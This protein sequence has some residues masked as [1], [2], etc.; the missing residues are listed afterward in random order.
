MPSLL[1]LQRNFSAA[2]VGGQT[3][4]AGIEVYRGN[5]FGNCAQ[6]LAAA[7]PIVRK[8]VGE[9]FF[10]A[11]ARVYARTHPSSGGDL[12]AFGAELAHFVARFPATQDL[13]YLPDVARMEWI[14]HRAYYARDNAPFDRA[15]LNH[16]PPEQYTALIPR[17]AAGSAV[18]ASDWPL[19]RI[20]EVHQ[21]D[22]VSDPSVDLNAGQDRILIFRP[23]WHIEV[24]SLSVGEYCFFTGALRSQPLGRLIESACTIDPEFDPSTALVR[25][26]N[27]GALAL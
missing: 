22:Y 27:C 26:I 5:V 3:A 12:N 10:D 18:L 19:A 24:R 2:L 11:I 21:D 9:D 25:W 13:P 17:L 16:V 7:Y 4:P 15:A 6:A 20:W 8:I 14:A 1:E 23:R